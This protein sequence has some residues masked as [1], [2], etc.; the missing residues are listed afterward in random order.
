MEQG[1]AVLMEMYDI[2]SESGEAVAQVTFFSL[3]LFAVCFKILA[4]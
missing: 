3:L 1:E 2:L 4:L